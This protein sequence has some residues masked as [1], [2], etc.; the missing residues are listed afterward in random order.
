MRR[1]HSGGRDPATLLTTLQQRSGHPEVL[2]RRHLAATCRLTAGRTL[3]QFGA[4]FL[5]LVWETGC[6][7]TNYRRF[8]DDDAAMVLSEHDANQ[9]KPGR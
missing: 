1:L 6:C 5:A 8:S 3:A 9:G 2:V 4:G 7:A